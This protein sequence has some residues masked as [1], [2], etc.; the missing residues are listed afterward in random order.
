MIPMLKEKIESELKGALKKGDQLRLSVFRMLSSAVHNKEIEKRTR[1]G[2]S[3]P[4]ELTE[5]EVMAVIRSEAKRREDAIEG[6]K[7]GNR[8]ERAEE[9]KRELEI[10]ESFLPQEMSDAEVLA[11]IAEG[12]VAVGASGPKDFGKLMAWVM[13][14]MKGQAS[15]ERV[16]RLVKKELDGL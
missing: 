3:E 8:P 6:Y 15:G 5:E 4:A 2:K 1:S 13:G 9:E 14:R 10:L 7:K 16:S 12:K 11:L